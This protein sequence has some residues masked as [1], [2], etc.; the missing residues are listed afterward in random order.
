MT[1]Y[2]TFLF[3]VEENREISMNVEWNLSDFLKRNSFT[4][5]NSKTWQWRT[6]EYKRGTFH[7]NS[8]DEEA[9]VGIGCIILNHQFQRDS[10]EDMYS[11]S[12]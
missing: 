11:F 3:I 2:F 12:N 1:N 10:E 9:P 8:K 7:E 5:M 4:S 6:G